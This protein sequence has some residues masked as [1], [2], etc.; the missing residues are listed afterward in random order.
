MTITGY[1]DNVSPKEMEIFI[2][3]FIKENFFCFTFIIKR[4]K[5]LKYPKLTVEDVEF[6]YLNEKRFNKSYVYIICSKEK[7]F[8]KKQAIIE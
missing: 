3:N 1:M 4:S 5:S 7:F 2:Q 6:V 8:E